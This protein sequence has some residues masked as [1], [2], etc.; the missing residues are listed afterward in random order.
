MSK[1]DLVLQ[2]SNHKKA[3]GKTCLENVENVERRYGLMRLLTAQTSVS[4]LRFKTADPLVGLLQRHGTMMMNLLGFNK[5]NGNKA[6]NFCCLIL[7]A[8]KNL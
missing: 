6:L 1:T 7:P 5:K 4:L 3:G 2:V 8:I